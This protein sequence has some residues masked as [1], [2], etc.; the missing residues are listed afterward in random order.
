MR[1]LC[2]LDLPL[3]PI[4]AACCCCVVGGAMVMVMV[5]CPYCYVILLLRVP[6]RLL[7]CC[8]F[9]ITRQGSESLFRWGARTYVMGVLNVTP[10]SFSDGGKHQDVTAAVAQAE[11]SDHDQN[12]AALIFLEVLVLHLPSCR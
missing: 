7:T 2:D 3:V 4:A 8:C 5:M 1:Q 6:K 12:S 10:D 9:V 11:V